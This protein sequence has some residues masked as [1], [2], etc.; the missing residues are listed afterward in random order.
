MTAWVNYIFK[1]ECPYKTKSLKFKEQKANGLTAEHGHAQILVAN[2]ARKQPTD[3]TGCAHP[4]P[5]QA[6]LPLHG[7]RLLLLR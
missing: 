4:Q 3:S 5:V 6:V 2:I 1:N 7:I